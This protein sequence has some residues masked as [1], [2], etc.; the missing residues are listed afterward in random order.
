MKDGGEGIEIFMDFFGDINFF[1]CGDD[2]YEWMWEDVL[3]DGNWY[4]V[5]VVCD[6]NNF[7]LFLDGV[8]VDIDFGLIG[9]IEMDEV[10]LIIGVF[11]L[12][13][14]GFDGLF[15]DVWIYDWVFLMSDIFEF[16][17]M[18]VV[19]SVLVNIVFGM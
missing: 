14:Y 9:E 5:I 16:Y 17:V 12:S 18:G 7:E 2:G 13:F 10:D 19:N 15:D 1:V 6:G 8:F 11:M 3:F 4:L